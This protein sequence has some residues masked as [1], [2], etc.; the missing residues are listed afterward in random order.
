[1]HGYHFRLGRLPHLHHNNLINCSLI[2]TFKIILD[3]Q[4]MKTKLV[5]PLSTLLIYLVCHQYDIIRP[6]KRKP[7]STNP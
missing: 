2:C 6:H 7:Q 1:M 4:T 3:E 5:H